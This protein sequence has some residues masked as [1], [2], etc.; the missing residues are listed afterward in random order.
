MS[1]EEL[2]YKRQRDIW[3][4]HNARQNFEHELINRKT[5]WLITSQTILFAAYGVTFRVTNS[6]DDPRDFRRVV[7]WA[8]LSL[9]IITFVGVCG[10]LTSKYL[11]WKLYRAYYEGAPQDLP[12]PLERPLPWGV[13]TWNTMGLALWPDVALPLVF[14]GAWTALLVLEPSAVTLTTPGM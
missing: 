4:D 14:I 8:G 5:T 12:T 6:V 2:R 1:N 3:A 9:A 7:A 11:A 10:L 13:K